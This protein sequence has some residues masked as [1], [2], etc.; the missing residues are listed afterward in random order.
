[1]AK[2][3]DLGRERSVDPREILTGPLSALRVITLAA[4]EKR[5]VSA[6]ATESAWYV[7]SG[8][9]SVASEGTREPLRPG[10]SVALPLGTEATL[11]AS[12]EG[13]EL[14]QAELTVPGD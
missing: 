5:L 10:S 7:L 4:A 9:G 8:S 3:Y 11:E 14:F 2:V 1:M 12:G 13:L 6:R